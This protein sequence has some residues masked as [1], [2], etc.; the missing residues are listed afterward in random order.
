MLEQEGT[1]SS[2]DDL[3]LLTVTGKKSRCLHGGLMPC[4]KYGFFT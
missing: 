1:L 4:H 2:Q 3:D